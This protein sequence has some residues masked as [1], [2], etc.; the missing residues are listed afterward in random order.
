MINK[1]NLLPDAKQHRLREQRLRRLATSAALGVMALAVGVP[2]LLLAIR[3]AQTL[4]LKRT[5]TQIDERKAQI[6]NTENIT[7]MLSVKDHLDSLP[8]L[9]S[10]RTRFSRL[11]AV[12]PRVTP[13]SVRLTDVEMAA[14]SSSVSF[15]GV[16]STYNEVEKF[17]K[18][19]VNHGRKVDLNRVEA[20]ITDARFSNVVVSDISGPSGSEVTF[21]ISANFIPSLIS[22]DSNEN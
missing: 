1:V 10:Q 16:S 8:A 17:Y 6:Q 4:T 3:G 20:N 5:Q 12:L 11:L 2:I 15:K 19:L 21:S 7:T 13:K 14:T 18:A 22:G 9:Y